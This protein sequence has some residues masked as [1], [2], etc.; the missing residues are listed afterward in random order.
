V[1]AA[2]LADRGLSYPDADCTGPVAL[3]LGS[4]AHGLTPYWLDAADQVVQIPMRG[5]ADSLN[6]ATAGAVLLYEAVR[7]RATRPG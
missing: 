2:A 4:E 1:Y 7:Q 3:L 6:V 5:I